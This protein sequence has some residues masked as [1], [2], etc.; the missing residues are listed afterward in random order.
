MR[1]RVSG[2]PRRTR[3]IKVRLSVLLVIPLVSLVALWGYAASVSLGKALSEQSAQT[4]DVQTG[5]ASQELLAQLALERAD[6][7]VWLRTGRRAPRSRL[8]ADRKLTDMALAHYRAG[9]AGVTGL[10]SAQVK[11]EI[12]A[13]YT[14]LSHLTADRTA[15]DAGTMTPLA[16]FQ[17]Y[18]AFVDS[19]YQFVHN[20][21]ATSDL[22]I[23]GY[24]REEGLIDSGRALEMVA[25][26]A[27]LVS[28]ALASG[29]RMSPAEHELFVQ[30]VNDRQLLEQ[31][32]LSNLGPQYD[33]RLSRLVTSPAYARF[34][35]MEN[36]I[37]VG[38]PATAPISVSPAVWQSGLASLT[39]SSTSANLATAQELTSDLARSGDTLLTQLLLVGG[40]GLAA[41]LVS[42]FLLVRFVRSIATELTRLLSAVRTLAE[43]RLPV[44]VGRLRRGEDVDVA[45]EAP[46]VALRSRTTEVARIAEAFSAVQRTAVQAAVGQAELRK[47]V[48]K[49]FRSLARRSQSLLHRQL[50]M[51]D[52]MEG[53]TEEPDALADLFRLDHLTTRM[54][55]HAEGLIILSGAAPGRG[56]RQPVPILEVL[57]GAIGEIEDYTRV[58][59]ITDSRDAVAGNA[60]ADVIHLLAELIEN[61]ANYSPPSTRIRV[62]ANQVGSGFAVEV[63]DRGLGIPADTMEAIN[64]RLANPP[65]FDLADSD[66]LGLFVVSQLAARHDVRVSLSASP[67]GGTTAIVL[68]PH[69]LVIPEPEAG[70]VPDD[71]GQHRELAP[72]AGHRALPPGAGRGPALSG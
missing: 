4:V 16:A 36:R 7:F 43:E 13:L 68:M 67:Y 39:A 25:R 11:P 3:S 59:I 26:E 12:A 40:G 46:P 49:V 60:V 62:L 17:V 51:L 33:V 19:L 35:A 32:A 27:G 1:H 21:V 52:S 10:L 42:A 64:Q 14:N 70:V 38:D 63:E 69:H 31:E 2:T 57:R 65:E 53:R 34:T 55:R 23:D 15:I 37:V 29:G 72:G 66:Q 71:N 41:V 24:V 18:D 30:S 5:T 58:D 9:M 50:S 47:G 20:E 28:G 54:R 48:N 45:A 22:A 6:S 61:A 56:W 8:D 44:L